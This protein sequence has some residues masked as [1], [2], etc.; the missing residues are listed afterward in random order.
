MKSIV[1]FEQNR[2][3]YDSYAQKGKTKTDYENTVGEA[4]QDTP[5]WL[6][7]LVKPMMKESR[8]SGNTFENLNCGLTMNKR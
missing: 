2:L 3:S 6:I 8:L 5:L 7:P 1:P 4:V